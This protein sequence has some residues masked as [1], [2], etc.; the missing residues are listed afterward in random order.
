[1]TTTFAFSDE[2]QGRL[3]ASGW[4]PQRR[5]DV[6]AW[7]SRNAAEGLGVWDY[8]VDVLTQFGGLHLA[9]ATSPTLVFDPNWYADGQYDR[10]HGWKDQLG[11]PVVPIAGYG[12]IQLVFLGMPSSMFLAFDYAIWPVGTSFEEGLST[13]LRADRTPKWWHPLEYRSHCDQKR[14]P[15]GS[16]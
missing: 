13:L 16:P 15:L 10:L 1:M 2:V 4:S 11:V 12:E 9:A 7:L 6:E 3:L 5:Y 8:A 14:C